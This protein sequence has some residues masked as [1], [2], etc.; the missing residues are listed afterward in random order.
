MKFINCSLH[1]LENYISDEKIVLFGV[2]KFFA[3]YGMRIFPTKLIDKV[4]YAIDNA[5]AGTEM[6]FYNRNISVYKPEHLLDEIKCTVILMSGNYMFEMYQQLED[7]QLGDGITCIAFPLVLAAT[8]GRKSEEASKKIF[9]TQK[10]QKI[11]KTIHCFWFSGEKKPGL[12][13][14]CIDSWKRVCP[15]YQ[16]KEW[17]MDNYDWEKHPFMKKAIQLKKWAFASDYAR[18]DVI[19]RQ[20]GIY[21]DMDVELIKKMDA[22]LGNEAFFSYDTNCS[23]DLATFGASAGNKLLE[24][25][26]HLYD[27][28][29]FTKDV[30]TMDWLCQPRYIQSVLKK[31]GVKLN[32][33]L[34]LL[35]GMVFLPRSY[36]A[37]KDFVSYELTALTKDTI[38][39]HHYITGWKEEDYRK[40]RME[41]NRKLWRLLEE[42]KEHV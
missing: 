19:F 41:N 6:E 11:E 12:Y 39:I 3:Y 29:E 33:D 9:D 15:E 10:E 35:N 30:A 7:M 16:I 13:Q 20:G 22:L 18:L 8:D 14:K 32:G 4:V 24:E 36:F 31:A 17:N 5:S 42:N 40:K 27:G 21:L 38:A 23:I 25:L 1:E 34:Q 2:G 28:V 37:P 26:M